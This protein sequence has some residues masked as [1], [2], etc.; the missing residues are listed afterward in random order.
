MNSPPPPPPPPIASPPII[1]YGSSVPLP[2]TAPPVL[3]APTIATLQQQPEKPIHQSKQKLKFVEWEK[4]NRRQLGNTI[5]DHL[6]NN[7]DSEEEKEEE[8]KEPTALL[9]DNSSIV[10]KLS[11]ADV[12]TSIEKTFAQK[13]AVD[14]SKRKR[15]KVSDM[16]ELLDSRKAYNMSIFLTSLP[17]DFQLSKLAQYLEEENKVLEEHV[18]ENLSKFAPDLEELNK[19]KSYPEE[20]KEKLSQPDQL[21]L[22]MMQIPQFKQRVMA[23]LFKITFWNAIERM[24]KVKLYTCLRML[25]R[26][27]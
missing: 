12:F 6:D 20:K 10:T 5:W 19:F 18:L 13:P 4:I 9:F 2:P 11:R 27:I 15:Q 17:K 24:E 25:C 23:L 1:T 14:L 16:V 22:Q 21:I 8:E 7:D 3:F 26:E